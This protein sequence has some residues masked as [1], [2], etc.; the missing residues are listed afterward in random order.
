MVERSPPAVLTIAKNGR[1][2]ATGS[3]HHRQKW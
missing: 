1:A 3:P 2:I